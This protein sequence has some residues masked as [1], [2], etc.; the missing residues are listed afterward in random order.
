[1]SKILR[2]IPAIV[3][4]TIIF[5]A[6]STTSANLPNYGMW[7]TFVKKGGH[8]TGYALLAICY[9]YALEF[10]RKKIWLAWL[11]AL[12]YAAS[13]EFHQSFTPGRHPA[14][15]DVL[16]FD[17]GGAALGLFVTGWFLRWKNFKAPRSA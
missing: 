9:W 5:F 11:L 15:L 10:D 16:L 14:V 6:S 4:M 7:D 13:D 8:M 2:W 12:A 17:G 3:M 1:M